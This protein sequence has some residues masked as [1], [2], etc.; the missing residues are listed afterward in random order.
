[1]GDKEEMKKLSVVMSCCNKA[2]LLCWTLLT[3]IEQ[4]TPPDEIIIID[5]GSN[6]G[7]GSVICRFQRVY[8]NANI[9]YYYNNNPDFTMCAWGLNCGIKKATNEII[10]LT[11][12]EILHPTPDVK[13]MLDH[14]NNP[15]NDR[16]L[17]RGCRLY[18]VFGEDL[19][20]EINR[21]N[22]RE[23]IAIIQRPEV[24]EWYQGL[25][26]VDGMITYMPTGGL[27]HIAGVLKKHL[28]AVGG[29]DERFSEPGH[30][31]WED[32]DFFQRICGGGGFYNLEEIESPEIIGIHL[33]HRKPSVIAEEKETHN[34]KIMEENCLREEYEVN[35]GKEWGVLR[36]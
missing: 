22:F 6:D 15:E 35:V 34:F 14:F 26:S 21:E 7:T 1:M 29:F 24:Q 8:P 25:E 36:E 2:K 10:M 33:P 28:L 32:V 5:D 4:E 13:I 23:P 12:P 3:L 9:K 19:L 18:Q 20:A 17:L 30:R 31:G 27:H 11:M 16:T